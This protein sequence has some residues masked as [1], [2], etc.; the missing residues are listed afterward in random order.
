MHKM[1]AIELLVVFL[2]GTLGG[3]CVITLMAV[4]YG[5]DRPTKMYAPILPSLVLVIVVF[6]WLG[7]YGGGIYSFLG[8]LIAVGITVTLVTVNFILIAAKKIKPLHAIVNRLSSGGEII[9]TISAE[10]ASSSAS[11]ADGSSSQAAAVEQTSAALSGMTSMTKQSADK[12][13]LANQLM[14]ETKQVVARAND[15][16]QTLIHSMEDIKKASEAISKIIRTI[17]EIAF[18]TNL[19]A[20]NAA[21]EA[22]RAGEA[23]SGFAVVAD[24]VRSLAMRSAEAAKN[25]AAMIEDTVKKIMEGS[26]VVTRTNNEFSEV[27]KSA[28]RIS[29]L[30]S[31]IASSSQEQSRG[32]HE[33]SAAV[34][35]LDR[36][37][38]TNAASADDFAAAAERIRV[39][40]EE[41]SELVILL[42]PL[43]GARRLDGIG[44]SQE[45]SP[46]LHEKSKIPGKTGKDIV[47]YHRA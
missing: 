47:P 9:S 36:V 15:S 1:I 14:N 34:T 17:D 35:D 21:V 46:A 32:V 28:T 38:Q 16:M 44:S 43:V 11:L 40:S 30:I 25:T 20:L 3:F 4:I 29:G 13:N 26:A 5:K 31:E 12:S 24:E 42:S 33:I 37:I 19:L 6:Y 39:A 45:E 41:F 27:T 8:K 18:Q 23:G 7:K 2:V 10:L 22:A